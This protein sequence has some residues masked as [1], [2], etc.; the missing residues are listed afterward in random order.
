MAAGTVPPKLPSPETRPVATSNL[1]ATEDL[2]VNQEDPPVAHQAVDIPFFELDTV[3]ISADP[4]GTRPHTPSAFKERHTHQTIQTLD[5]LAGVSY[6]V[7]GASAESDPWLL[8]HCKFNDR[9]FL[10][11]HQ[12]HFRNAG[13][14]PF[15]EKI[16]CHFLVSSDQLY[17]SSKAQLPPPDPLNTHEQLNHIVPP[18]CGQRLVVLFMKFIFPTLPIISR[19]HFG[20]A[21]AGTVPDQDILQRTPLCLLAAIY[22][23]AQ[24]FA[25]FDDYLCL[26]DAYAPP[27][28]DLLWRMVLDLLLRDIHTARLSTLQAGILY[29][30]RPI[31]A[32]ESAVADSAFTWSLVGMLVGVAM[33]LGLQLDCRLMGLPLWEKRIRRRLWW[34]IYAEDKWRCLL[35]GRPSYIGSDDW[36]ATDLSDDDFVMSECLRLALQQPASSSHSS[37][38]V[39]TAQPFQQLIQLSRIADELQR[40]LFTLKASQRLS[41]DFHA[42]LEIA[43][44][45][46]QKLKEWYAHSPVSSNCLRFACILLE[47]FVFRA[48]L[49]PMVRSAAPPPLL[50]EN[51]E[52]AEFTNQF[53]DLLAQ[54]FDAEEIEPSMAIDM[55]DENGMGNAVLRAADNCAAKVIRLVM[56][57][58]TSDLSSFW[59]RW[60]RVGFATVSNFLLLLLVQAPTKDHALRAKSL[61]DLWRQ[62]LRNQSTGCPAM[63]LGLVRLDG[64]L[65]PGLARNYYLPKQVKEVLEE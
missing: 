15:D 8:R 44:P 27:A 34:A 60:S 54:L 11:F 62:T 30:H 23:S 1:Q 3:R 49:R 64:S 25:K 50:E 16:P 52:T 38:D 26:I 39:L 28:T 5:G 46:L 36:D 61:V 18:E 41:P 40:S 42:T 58:T 55:S 47:V 63:N 21:A 13:G 51:F 20:L 53:N 12:V 35:I 57:M 14:V 10:S 24:P 2:V 43:R 45:L 65:W 7:N 32:T 6:Q 19:S 9:G 29:L 59:Y 4:G 37:H 17:E 31:S 48:L 56:R 22:A 33:S